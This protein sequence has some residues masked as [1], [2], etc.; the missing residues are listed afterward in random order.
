VVRA[1]PGVELFVV[2]E[3]DLQNGCE[4]I[5]TTRGSRSSSIR[6]SRSSHDSNPTWPIAVADQKY[7]G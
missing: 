1:D 4:L 3:A 6:L 7:P 2:F 5:P